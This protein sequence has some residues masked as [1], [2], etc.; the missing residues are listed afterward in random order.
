MLSSLSCSCLGSSKW[1]HMRELKNL[2]GD[3][4]D[5]LTRGVVRLLNA[6]FVRAGELSIMLRQQD[7]LLKQRAL[8]TPREA[9]KVLAAGTRSIGAL[10][11]GWCTMDHPDPDG[12]YLKAVR[13]FLLTDAGR[14]IKAIFWEC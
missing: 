13:H 8:L 7:L 14:G 3:L 11:Y 1:R 5:A 12:V 9:A 4:S 10:T 6:D 2:D